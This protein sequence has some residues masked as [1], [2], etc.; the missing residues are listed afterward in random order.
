MH[1]GA[2]TDRRVNSRVSRYHGLFY[3]DSSFRPVPLEQHFLGIKGKANS[4]ESRKNLDRATYTKA[5]ELVQ[6]GHQV[7]VF[8]HARKETVKAAMALKDTAS[9]EGFLEDF[10]CQDHPLWDRYRREIGQSRNREMKELFDNGFGIHHAGMLRSDRNL[11]ERLFLDKAI[12]VLCCTA[13]LA[14]G[15]NLPA[16]AGILDITLISISELLEVLIKGTQVYDSAKGSFVDLSV[17]DVLQIFGRAGRPGLEDEG[18]GF[19]LTTEEKLTHYLDSVTAQVSTK[20]Q[21][22]CICQRSLFSTPSNHSKTHPQ[23]LV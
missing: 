23:L 9:L 1:P 21:N 5:L 7:M 20:Y 4:P 10:S 8:V 18:Q 3:F 13:T 17:L 15:V 2:L 14:W 22:G 16:H 19:I 11:M 6:A 12:K